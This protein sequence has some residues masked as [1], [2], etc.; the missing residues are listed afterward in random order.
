MI[1]D[2]VFLFFDILNLSPMMHHTLICT[3]S[4]LMDSQLN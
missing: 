4:L 1:N 2:R 3:F